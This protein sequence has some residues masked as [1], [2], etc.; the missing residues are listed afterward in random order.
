MI[1]ISSALHK[2]PASRKRELLANCSADLNQAR[3]I[4][5]SIAGQI[6]ATPS[7]SRL[8]SLRPK[9]FYQA[10]HTKIEKFGTRRE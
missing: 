9:T 8:S 10:C 5:P 4:S 1:G 7:F 3:G 2:R 6:F